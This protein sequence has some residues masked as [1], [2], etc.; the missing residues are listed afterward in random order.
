[1]EDQIALLT[2]LLAK[3]EPVSRPVEEKVE[4][5]V[6]DPVS[7]PVEEPVE[8]EKV[9][10]QEPEQKFRVKPKLDVNESVCVLRKMV[11]D[12]DIILTKHQKL[13]IGEPIDGFD[14]ADMQ[15]S[16]DICSNSYNYLLTDVDTLIENEVDRM[17]LVYAEN[18]KGGHTFY[19]KGDD[20]LFILDDDVHKSSLEIADR[21]RKKV[22]EAIVTLYRAIFIDTCFRQKFLEEN[23]DFRQG[24][25]NLL[26]LCDYKKTQE[27]VSEYVR[28]NNTQ[29]VHEKHTNITG[30]DGSLADELLDQITSDSNWTESSLLELFEDYRSSTR[31]QKDNI[32]DCVTQ[33]SLL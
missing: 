4:E 3:N 22:L 13:K 29:F 14:I 28:V 7:E 16:S 2:S 8:E 33:L 20:G 6:S 18:I 31:E 17:N 5:K 10:E 32:C 27:V 9:P 11:F 19:V 21:L 25:I 12:K 24:L 1:M 30:K 26:F 15:N 23:D